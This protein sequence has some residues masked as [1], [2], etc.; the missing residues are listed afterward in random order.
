MENEQLIPA[1]ALCAQY[2]IEYAF[3]RSLQDYGLVEIVTV[4]DRCFLHP[5]QLLE[6]ERY[7]HFHYDMDI[8]LEGIEVISRLLGRIRTMQRRLNLLQ[9]RLHVYGEELPTGNR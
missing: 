2:N 4:E 5:E 3:I 8:N 6:V 9:N 7:I 1:D